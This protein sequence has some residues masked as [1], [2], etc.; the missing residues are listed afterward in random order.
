[1]AK[2][3]FSFRL[4]KDEKQVFESTTQVSLTKKS[5]QELEQFVIDHSFSAEM[6]DIPAAIYDKCWQTAYECAIRDYPNEM[7]ESFSLELE[8]YIPES[9]LEQLSA[10]TQQKVKENMPFYVPEEG[11]KTEETASVET[12]KEEI[13]PAS[14][15][16]NADDDILPTK[17]NTLYLT[18]K[19][20]YF[21]QI[22]SGSKKKEYREIKDTTYKKYLECDEFGNPYC[23][24][25]KLDM[26]DP[27]AGD[28][29]IWNN[30]V[31]P[32]VSKDAHLFL[33]L[34]VGYHKE[35]DTAIVEIEDI[36]FEPVVGKNGKPARFTFDGQKGYPDE[37]G[38]LCLWNIV[39]HLGDVIELHRH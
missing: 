27:L 38:E 36:S 24:E 16:E 30:G 7:D 21:D 23:E 32:Y 11:S 29:C 10:E 15:A 19:Q 2:Y 8:D 14:D 37:N 33:N 34:A 9:F 25:G 12:P 6:Q 26:N 39:Y 35:R 20:M 28:I 31:Y 5:F 18:I 17:E 22:I 4:F 3:S 13:L 1:M